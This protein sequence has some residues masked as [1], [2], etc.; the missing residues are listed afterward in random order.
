[1][2]QPNYNYYN[3]ISNLERERIKK[4]KETCLKNKQKRKRKK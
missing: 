4:H 3:P 1:M 2:L